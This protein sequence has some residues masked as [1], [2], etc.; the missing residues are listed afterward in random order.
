MPHDPKCSGCPEC[1][2]DQF[3]RAVP[4]PIVPNP[5]A[6]IKTPVELHPSLDPA[7]QPFGTPCDSYAINLIV[8]EE[9]EQK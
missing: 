2:P 3:K 5:Y 8:R 9:Q 4:P 6:T 7:Y 1:K